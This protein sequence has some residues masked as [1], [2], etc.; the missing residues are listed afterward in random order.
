[1]DIET[2]K[3]YQRQPGDIGICFKCGVKQTID[4]EGSLILL[5]KSEEA[6]LPLRTRLLL[7]RATRA[8]HSQIGAS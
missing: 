6:T 4:A 2:G 3:N 8:W 1:M 7:E 5:T